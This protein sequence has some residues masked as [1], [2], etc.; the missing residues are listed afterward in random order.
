[1][2]VTALCI[3]LLINVLVL[4]VLEDQHCYCAEKA[5]AASL[6]I[7]PNRLQLFEYDSISIECEGYGDF[8]EWRVMG[9]IMG[10]ETICATH[11]ETSRAPCFIQHSF[12]SD[13]G[14]YWCE[15]KGG[16]RSNAVSITV[17]AG[18]VI[19]ESP[20]LPVME[21][22]D[23]TLRCRNKT[24][25]SVL[26]ADFYKDGT[27]IESG[28]E[29]NMTIH[30]VS[31]SAEGFYKCDI[32]GV[33]ESADSWLA[34]GDEETH[35]PHHHSPKLFLLWITVVMV[36]VALPL[37]VGLILCGK[38]R[39][40]VCISSKT[41]TPRSHS[42]EAGVS[43]MTATAVINTPSAGTEPRTTNEDLFYDTIQ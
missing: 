43:S 26:I 14:E 36:L 13:S 22:D 18:S 11:W 2:E 33:G 37:M 7:V 28:Y 31:K 6:R 20:A 32:S 19:L 30:S 4:L 17:T 8:T 9:R 27:L 10:V 12:S 23:V 15:A 41:S 24:M 38:R 1:M 21:G 5:D 42:A 40:L 35:P 39:G 25:S 3:R 29:G 16:G 34:V